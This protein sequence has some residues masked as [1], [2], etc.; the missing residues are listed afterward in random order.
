VSAKL[1]LQPFSAPLSG[2]KAIAFTVSNLDSSKSY[3]IEI[4]NATFNRTLKPNTL[5]NGFVSGNHVYVEGTAIVSG[6]VDLGLTEAD[7]ATL[8][9]RQILAYGDFLILLHFHF[10]LKVLYQ[11]VLATRFLYILRLLDCKKKQLLKFI[12]NQTQV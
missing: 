4:E 10:R 3:R 7:S 1:K 2:T 11:R 12:L 8:K 6:R 5:T 9:R